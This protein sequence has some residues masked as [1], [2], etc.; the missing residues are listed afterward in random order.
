MPMQEKPDYPAPDS[1]ESRLLPTLNVGGLAHC[2]LPLGGV[3]KPVYHRTVEEIWYC[4]KGDG[5][6][7]RKQD[8]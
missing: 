8:P 7:W 2:T 5:E 3:P 6:V 1:S 4:I